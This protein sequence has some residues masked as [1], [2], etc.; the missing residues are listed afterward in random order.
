[1][2]ASNTPQLLKHSG[3]VLS[4]LLAGGQFFTTLYVKPML[5]RM[6]TS[7]AY[8]LFELI[9][10]VGQ[11]V[12]PALTLMSSASFATAAYLEKDI[13]PTNSRQLAYSAAL[14][15]A[16]LPYTRFA[17]W[18][19]LTKLFAAS[20]DKVKGPNVKA[21]LKMWIV[22]HYIRNIFTLLGFIGGVAATV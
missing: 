2:T 20:A 21:L 16:L 13:N 1:M 5:D 17:M 22:H 15:F 12:F 9:Y 7:D 8:N 10:H 4:G 19:T 18:P 14:V 3:I 11:V 6:S